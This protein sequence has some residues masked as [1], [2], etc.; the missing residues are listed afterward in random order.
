VRLPQSQKFSPRALDNPL[1]LRQKVV[2]HRVV[3]RLES[4]NRLLAAGNQDGEQGYF[5]SVG[6]RLDLANLP[7]YAATETVSR[8]LG[9]VGEITQRS[10]AR[11]Y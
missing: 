8:A 1:K 10:C 2:V 4:F 7:R 9:E 6:S 5:L 3:A 11:R